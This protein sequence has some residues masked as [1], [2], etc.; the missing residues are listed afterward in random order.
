[1]NNLFTKKR[2]IVFAIAL[3]IIAVVL[4]ILVLVLKQTSPS[5]NSEENRTSYPTPT[6]Y[7]AQD[8]Q[9]SYP[10]SFTRYEADKYLTPAINNAY[11][12]TNLDSC[13][14]QITNPNFPDLK[15]NF[16]NCD[17]EVK[18]TSKEGLTKSA[19]VTVFATFIRFTNLQTNNIVQ[20][21]FV[22]S[23]ASG[24]VGVGEC[25][26]DNS[27]LTTINEGLYK[28][29]TEVNYANEGVKE[30]TAYKGSNTIIFKDH[31]HFNT[32]VDYYLQNYK[33][34]SYTQ[35]DYTVCV[36]PG[37]DLEVKT[38]F[39]N[40]VLTIAK[41]MEGFQDKESMSWGSIYLSNK[42]ANFVNLAEDLLKGFYF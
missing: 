19:M 17:W 24:Y 29:T 11:I 21:S 33:P 14:Q 6:S 34:T 32:L 22:Q 12:F 38:R 15:L 27:K 39:T 31:E 16:N 23:V 36:P 20:V 9:V 41:G 4:L 35:T 28:Y 25:Y 13:L 18:I 30:V 7:V 3:P 8:I 37:P 1:M 2:L 42:D 40:Q 10:N 26:T 5:T